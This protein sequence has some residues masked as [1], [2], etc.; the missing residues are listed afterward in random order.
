M[1]EQKDYKAII[2]YITTQLVVSFVAGIAI[3]AIYGNKALDIINNMTGIISFVSLAIIAAI[4][5]AIYHKRIIE[6]IKRLTKKDIII[7]LISSIVWIIINFI[8][9]NLMQN[10]NIDMNNQDAVNTALGNSKIFTMLTVV[11]FAPLVEE[12]VFRYSLSTII[13]NNIMFIMVSSIIFGAFHALNIAMILYIAMGVVFSVI[14]LK[15]DK[16][17]MASILVHLINNLIA[18][19][20]MLMI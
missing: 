11:I 10:L 3:S 20:S 2:I 16:N 17:I 6:D 7:I 19:I 14:Y 4:F 12:I 8:I 15:T 1:K 9:S 18:V 5:I 13:K